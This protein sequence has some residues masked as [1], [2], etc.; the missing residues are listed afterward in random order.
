MLILGFDTSTS[1]MVAAAGNTEKFAEITIRSQKRHDELL[2]ATLEHLL[3][4]MGKSFDAIEYIAVGV[5]PGSFT[6]IRVAMATA[7]G[8]MEALHVPAITFNTFELLISH[9]QEKTGVV[10]IP[11]RRGYVYISNY[12][13][14][15]QQ[16]KPELLEVEKLALRLSEGMYDDKTLVGMGWYQL[17]NPPLN[18]LNVIP[19]GYKIIEFAIEKI[20][21]GEKID[22]PSG[23][24]PLYLER[25]I[26]EIRSASS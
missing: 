18:V 24:T 8:I 12:V 25:P 1:F 15:K 4:C 26:V 19:R 7:M 14:G 21:R 2:L 16:G 22:E 11:A 6:G 9:L 23:L 17:E 20:K 5:G 13:R 3:Q 10:A